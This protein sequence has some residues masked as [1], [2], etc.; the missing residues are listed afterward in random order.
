MG[1]RRLPGARFCRDGGGG[2]EVISSPRAQGSDVSRPACRSIRRPRHAD[3]IRDVAES[4]GP[5]RSSAVSDKKPE[6]CWIVEDD[7]GLQSQLKWC[8]ED[9]EVVVAGDRRV[10]DRGA[11][12]L[13]AAGGAAGSRPAAGRRRGHR[14]GWPRSR[15]SWRCAA[16]K[17]IVVT[18]NDDRERR[19]GGRP[20]AP[21]TS[22]R[23]RSIPTCCC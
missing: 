21:T 3:R 5:A 20:A 23:S 12:S 22:T 8:F 17:V 6:N 13:R 2:L 18:G 9:Y 1:I 7:P 15:R 14:R 10:G 4:S 19:E 11:A 16:T